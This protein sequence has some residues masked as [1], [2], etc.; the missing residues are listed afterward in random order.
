MELFAVEGAV[1]RHEA[2]DEAAAAVRMP[3]DTARTVL[4][5]E[6]NTANVELIRR[7]LDKRPGVQLISTLPTLTMTT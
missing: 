3:A 1:E 6:D 4:Y 7:I 2:A 5:V